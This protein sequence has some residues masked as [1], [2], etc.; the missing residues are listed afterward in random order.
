MNGR[1]AEYGRGRAAGN[2]ACTVAETPYQRGLLEIVQRVTGA[3]DGPIPVTA[4]NL[5]WALMQAADRPRMANFWRALREPAAY[6][7]FRD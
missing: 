7:V 2:G 6:R 5:F 3:D 4:G 1:R